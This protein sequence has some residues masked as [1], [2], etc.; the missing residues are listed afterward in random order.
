MRLRL[1]NYFSNGM[2][3]FKA[4]VT[5]ALT[6]SKYGVNRNGREGH[7]EGASRRRFCPQCSTRVSRSANRCGYCRKFLPSRRLAAYVALL[8][9]VLIAVAACL[10]RLL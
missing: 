3:F 5:V 9:T 2:L 6:A 1:S 7:R 4:G 10:T 8:I